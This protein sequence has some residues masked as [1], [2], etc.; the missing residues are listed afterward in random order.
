M[1]HD[2]LGHDHLQWHPNW[3][4]ITPISDLITELD[5]ITDFDFIINFRGGFH[6]TL[7]RVRLAKEDA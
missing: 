3:S 2:I 7:Q 1:W 4:D 5:F 6:R